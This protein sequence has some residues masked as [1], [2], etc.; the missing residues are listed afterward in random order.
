MSF[1]LSLSIFT[2]LYPSLSLTHT[3][4]LS[5]PASLSLTL[6]LSSSLPLSPS[7]LLSL[8]LFLSLSLSLSLSFSL[9]LP[10]YPTYNSDEELSEED[11]DREFYGEDFDSELPRSSVQSRS[12]GE[13]GKR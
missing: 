4:S 6:F 9:F 8:S 2:L 11:I 10:L 13:K 12:S 7:L 1:L 3:I 5:L